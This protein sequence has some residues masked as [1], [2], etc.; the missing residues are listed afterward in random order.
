MALLYF[1]AGVDAREGWNTVRDYAEETVAG[2]GEAGGSS[3]R[4]KWEAQQE[5]A[6]SEWEVAECRCYSTGECMLTEE[7]F[8]EREGRVFRV[9]RTGLVDTCP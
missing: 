2:I 6:E 1:V 5:Q 9:G 8:L 4:D 3:L 7:R